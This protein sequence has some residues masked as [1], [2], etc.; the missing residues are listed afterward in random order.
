MKAPQT[1][2][3]TDNFDFL[4][5]TVWNALSGKKYNGEFK[6][7]L[8]FFYSKILNIYIFNGEKDDLSENGFLSK[9]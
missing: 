2:D 3:L 7:F 6:L 4:N 1:L 5:N 9:N 8:A